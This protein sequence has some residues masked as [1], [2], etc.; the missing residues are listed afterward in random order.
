MN[1]EVRYLLPQIKIENSMIIYDNK[2][3]TFAPLEENYS[4]I[5][6]S[7]TFANTMRT[8]HEALWETSRAV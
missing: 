2:V 6:E 7:K 3:V 5:I 4:F 1:R 8:F